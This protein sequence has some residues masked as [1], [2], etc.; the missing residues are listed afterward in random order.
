MEARDEKMGK[1]MSAPEINSDRTALYIPA[2]DDNTASSQLLTTPKL[3]RRLLRRLLECKSP[4]ISAQDIDAKLRDANLR[5]QQ[6]YESLSSKAR[7]NSRSRACSSSKEK[8]T[9]GQLETKLNAAEQKRLSILKNIQNRLA[10]TDELRQAAKNGAEMCFTRKCDELGAKVKSRVH[11]AEVNRMVLLKV[12]RQ[13]RAAKRERAAQ[14]LMRKMIQESN[15]KEC[16]RAALHQKRAAAENKRLGLLEAEKSRARARSLKVQRVANSVYNQRETERNKLKN[17]LEDR[18]QRA[19]RLRTEY[20]RMRASFHFPSRASSEMIKHGELLS[21]KLA[22]CWR[23]FVRLKGTMFDLA[24]AYA[25]L[26]INRKSVELMPFERL[27]MQIESAA[28]IQTAKAL[29]HRLE[30]RIAIRQETVG[31]NDY[32]HMENIDHLLK[33]VVT[34]GKRVRTPNASRSTGVKKVGSRSAVANGST[35][36]PRYPVRIVLCAYMIL[37]HPDTIFNGKGENDIA[38]AEA[39]ETFVKEF[40]LLVKIILEGPIRSPL[41]ETG[42]PTAGRLNFSSQLETFDKAWCSY[43]YCFVIWKVKDVKSFEG[44]LVRAACELETLRIQTCKQTSGTEY[45][46]HKLNMKVFLDQVSENLKL[47]QLKVQKLSGNAGLERMES[48]LSDTRKRFIDVMEV[49]SSLASSSDHFSQSATGSSH[50]SSSCASSKDDNVVEGHNRVG[51]I[52]RSLSK[53]DDSSL[54]GEVGSAPR[55]VLDDHLS[56]SAKLAT[57]NELLVNEIVHGIH[58]GLADG[59]NVIKEDQGSIKAKVRDTMEKAFW[60]SVMESLK[61][62]NPDYSWIL[63]LVQEVRDELFEMAPSSWRLEIDQTIDM[64]IL[65]QVL[66]SETLDTEYLRRILE[67]ALVTLQKLSAPAKEDELKSTH[68]KLLKELD[69]I[70]KAGD[71]YTASFTTLVIRSLRYVLQQIQELKH[72]ISKARINMLQPLI[73]GPAGF[74]Y[75]GSAFAN[76]YGSPIDAP[77]SLPLV[78]QWLSAVMADSE[79][80]WV[81]HSDSVSALGLSDGRY[82]QEPYPTTLRTG[83]NIL[84]TSTL[85]VPTNT[86]AEAEQPECSGEKLDLLLR[87]GLL[88]LVSDVEGLTAEMLPETLKLNLFRLRAIQ[89]QLQK[90]IVICTS[91]LVL[92]QTIVSE[93][94]VTSLI[95]TENVISNSAKQLSELL[96]R[97]EDVGL[98]KIVETINWSPDC[99]DPEKSRARKEVMA[100][101]LGR[102]LRAGDGVFTRV[103]RSVHLAARGVVLGGTGAKGRKLA[104]TALKRVGAALLTDNVVD[105]VRGLVVMANVS[106]RVHGAWYE[107]YNL[108]HISQPSKSVSHRNQASNSTMMVAE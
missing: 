5:R 35:R 85:G 83:G 33:R 11:Q 38:L 49:G 14:L 86:V 50:S 48:A 96:D 99:E 87:L 47:L 108:K 74:E 45:G 89:S 18:L 37:G 100:N 92:R 71:I 98:S 15:Y 40:E 24:T 32:F 54:R 75:L 55:S 103:S 79:Q 88:N 81:E 23:R 46:D 82:S 95:D 4:P 12:C 36:L 8:G 67:V 65:T 73:K 30:S 52:V 21:S 66:K 68:N 97:S 2:T 62:D 42:F 29:L 58:S 80:I 20:L 19:K 41:K 60:D 16:V 28:T 77:R 61:Q 84:R 9:G 53:G 51:Y 57:D 72:D 6:F 91:I 59:L 31:A 64:D 90:I 94:L 76:R 107:Q 7:T 44:D 105:A 43:L 10:R 22:R 13:R 26:D 63:K 104:E 69:A 3:P 102:S 56:T 17:R 101:M 78:K 25:S 34:P 70:S 93:H 106:A 27:A 1:D 39:A